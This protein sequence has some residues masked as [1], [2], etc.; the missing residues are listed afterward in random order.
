MHQ[1]KR[2]P[3]PTSGWA[4]SLAESVSFITV[5]YRVGSPTEARAA[6]DGAIPGDESCVASRFGDTIEFP[7]CSLEEPEEIFRRPCGR[8]EVGTTPDFDAR[9]RDHLHSVPSDRSAGN[10]RMIRNMFERTFARLA[11]RIISSGEIDARRLSILSAEDLPPSPV[12]ARERLGPY[13]WARL[14][15][16]R[17]WCLSAFAVSSTRRD[18]APLSVRSG[19]ID[20]RD[21]SLLRRTCVGAFI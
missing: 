11:E 21:K 17:R 2:V 10:A 13:L 20:V 15:R 3:S 12:T 19:R 4:H 14:R 16:S 6:I 9:L 1:T 5:P 7:D 18:S 8:W